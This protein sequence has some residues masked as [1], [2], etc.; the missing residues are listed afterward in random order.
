MNISQPQLSLSNNSAVTLRFAEPVEH[1]INIKYLCS[2][3]MNY[4]QGAEDRSKSKII[5][6]PRKFSCVDGRC[7]S[8]LL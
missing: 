7:H 6:L 8:N 5:K 3:C 2:F 4:K 1:L